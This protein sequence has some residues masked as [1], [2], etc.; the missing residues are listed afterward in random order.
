MKEAVLDKKKEN[1]G[2]KEKEAIKENLIDKDK[3]VIDITVM[4]TIIIIS[5]LCIFLV[6]GYIYIKKTRSNTQFNLIG[7]TDVVLE[8]GSEYLDEGYNAKFNNKDANAK[9]KVT[10]NLDVN[11]V[12][13]YKIEYNLQSKFYNVNETLCR[14]VTIQDTTAPVLTVD[15]DKNITIYAGDKFTTPKYTAVDN[16]DGD[17]T[18]NVKVESN[19]NSEKNG[20]Y[21]VNYYIKDSSGNESSETINVT[22]KKKKNPYIVVSIANQTLKYYEYDNLVLS[23]N[24]VTGI[25]GKTPTGTFRV[26]NK[27]RNIILEGKDYK[28]FVNYWIAFKGVSFGFHDASWRS[29]FGGKIYKTNGSHGCVNMPYAKVRQ[30]YNMVSI[31]TPV[32]IK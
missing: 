2:N 23:S 12:G 31:G 32:Y 3:K 8:A 17:I 16:Y 21:H 10:T 26:L 11:K 7:K 14:N 18:N 15:S 5:L 25:N 24:I 13:T 9:V 19:V 6:C 29:N 30:L 1:L 28:S 4:V 20:T 27:A 22:V